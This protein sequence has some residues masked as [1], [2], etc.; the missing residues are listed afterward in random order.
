ML[1]YGFNQG[2]EM[3]KALIISQTANANDRSF[4]ARVGKS[5]SAGD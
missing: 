4:R 5:A 2:N 3:S 1:L